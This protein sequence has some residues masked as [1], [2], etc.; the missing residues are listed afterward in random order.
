[1]THDELVKM[2]YQ[3][4]GHD[5]R[6]GGPPYCTIHLPKFEFLAGRR[7]TQERLR[8][9]GVGTEQLTGK[10]VLDLGCNVGGV[11]FECARLGA[12]FVCGL[13]IVAERI[14]MANQIVKF[15]GL[16]DIYFEAGDIMANPSPFEG[17]SF[18]IVFCLALDGWVADRQRLYK[19][20]GELTRET[21]YLETHDGMVGHA[22]SAVAHVNETLALLADNGFEH[23]EVLD[24]PQHDEADASKQHYRPNIVA[25]KG[26]C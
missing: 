14:A 3:V 9:F 22:T 4:G 10:T 25:R 5:L 2:M 21:L 13:D 16:T 11:A 8:R 23:V 20:L 19:I 7:N 26:R 1:M 15:C 17:N 12:R 6:L 24:E 18:D